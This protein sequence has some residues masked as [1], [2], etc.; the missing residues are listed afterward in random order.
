MGGRC[1]L[2]VLGEPPERFPEGVILNSPC[3]WKTITVLSFLDGL[4]FVGLNIT[5]RWFF[6]YLFSETK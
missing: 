5:I 4:Y 1:H 3:M 6:R 2:S